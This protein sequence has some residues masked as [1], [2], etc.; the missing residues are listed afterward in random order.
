MHF[1]DPLLLIKTL[2]LIGIFLIIFAESGLFFGFF[3]PGDSLLFIAGLLASEGYLRILPLL[4]L[5]FIG[6]VLGDNVGY[7]FGKRYGERIWSKE[8]S[9]FFKRSYVGRTHAFYEKYGK[10]I[11][12]LCRFIPIVRTFA[13]IMAGVGKMNYRIFFWYNVIGGFLWTFVVTLIGYY[14][15]Q[16][17]PMSQKY[18]FPIVV[19]I[20]IISCIPPAIEFMRERK[21]TNK[22]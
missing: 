7:A 14:L 4:A 16:T 21:M 2:G 10:K 11:I 17:V 8:N 5:A 19:A 22:K 12:I 20:I 1:L 6:A 9:F 15:G 13:P 18:I 3:L